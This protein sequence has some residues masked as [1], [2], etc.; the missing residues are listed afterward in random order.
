[1]TGEKAVNR[2]YEKLEKSK[3]PESLIGNYGYRK[4]LSVEG[5]VHVKVDEEKMARASLWDG[6]HGVL[7]NMKEEEMSAWRI[8]SISRSLAS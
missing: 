3:K 1:V 5:D 6:L 2:L 4:F 7:T 8:E